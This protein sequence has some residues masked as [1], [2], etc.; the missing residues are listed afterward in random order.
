MFAS[1]T[2]GADA[3]VPGGYVAVGSQEGSSC[4]SASL[5]YGGPRPESAALA[6]RLPTAPKNRTGGRCGSP[7]PP[8]LLSADPRQSRTAGWQLSRYRVARLTT[9][10]CRTIR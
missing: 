9:Q 2:S 3:I 1:V 8:A 4:P 10:G 5:I 7:R 6:G